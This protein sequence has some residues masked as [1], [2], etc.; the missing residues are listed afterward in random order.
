MIRFR[1][2]PAR[3]AR[4]AFAALLLLG[5]AAPATGGTAGDAL[6]ADDG[7]GAVKVCAPVAMPRWR[8]MTPVPKT[9]TF[10]DCMGFSGEM[11]ASHFQLGC[12]FT[13]V[14]PHAQKYA[15]GPV[16]QIEKSALGKSQ[17]PMPNCGW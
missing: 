16:V 9:W 15:W 7:T 4:V 6:N 13:N 17:A 2:P 3:S 1:F 11:G 12:L 8:S 10:L 5:V 14:T